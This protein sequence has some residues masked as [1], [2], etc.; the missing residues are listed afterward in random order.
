MK[1]SRQPPTSRA[2]GSVAAGPMVPETGLTRAYLPVAVVVIGLAAL[3]A[4]VGGSRYLVSVATLMVVLICYGIGFNVVFGGTG[5][6]MLSIGALAAVAAYTSALLGQQSALPV[7]VTLPS[8]VLL[9]TVIGALL[10][11]IA[12]RRRLDTIFFGV[13]TL[14]ASLVVHNLLL[15]RRDLTGGETGLL[16]EGGAGTA[17]REPLVGYYLVLVVLAVGLAGHRAIQRSALGW[18]FRAVRDDPVAAEFAGVDVART[19]VAAATFG[20]ALVGAAGSVYAHVDGFIS[21][22]TYGFATVDVRVMVVVVLGGLGTLVGPVVGGIAVTLL[23]ELLRP[24]GQLR[25]A[26]YGALLLVVFLGLPRGVVPTLMAAWHRARPRRQHVSGDR[27][28]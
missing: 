21:P 1:G 6:L 5:Q 12:V 16:V 13:V 8:G 9:A 7:A 22:T 26:A 10:S 25:V 3:P 18:A 27:A 11:W 23:D 19:K 17:L 2:F 4:A 28:P 14:T 15:G 24:L 20:S